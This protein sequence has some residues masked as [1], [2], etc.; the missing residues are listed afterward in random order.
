MKFFIKKRA[1]FLFLTLFVTISSFA[2]VTYSGGG[3]GT[4]SNPY[5]LLTLNDWNKFADSVTNGNSYAGKYLKLGADIANVTNMVGTYSSGT[6]A[7]YDPFKGN[8]D[9]DWHKITVSLNNNVNNSPVEFAAPFAIV[10]G[11]T[12]SNLIVDG[13]ITN[14]DSKNAAGIVSCVENKSD[15][16]TYIKNCISS[17][18]ITSDSEIAAP[19]HG[20][21]V[22]WLYQGEL[23]FE[24]CIFEGSIYG[25]TN[26]CAGFLGLV[27]RSAYNTTQVTYTNCAQVHTEI[28]HRPNTVFGTFHLPANIDP[29]GNW[30]TAYFT[31]RINDRDNQGTHAYCD[32]D[33]N[34]LPSDYN[35]ILKKYQREHAGDE[36]TFYIPE[37]VTDI[38][39]TNI[40]TWPLNPTVKF[41][42]RTLVKDVDYTIDGKDNGDGTYKIWIYAASNAYYGTLT[43]DNVHVNDVSSW[44]GLNSL[45]S[46]TGTQTKYITLDKDYEAGSGDAAFT[47]KGSVVLD[48]N[49]HKINRKLYYKV[50]STIYDTPQNNGYVLYV[51]KGAD[52]TIKDT[53]P[54]HSGVITGGNNIGSGGGIKSVGNLTL[55]NIKVDFNK[56][57]QKDNDWGYG[58]GVY[59]NSELR[60]IGGSVTNNVAQGGGGGIYTEGTLVSIVDATIRGNKAQSKGGGIRIKTQGGTMNNCRVL[61]NTL[62]GI[63]AQDG[64]GIYNDGQGGVVIT[65]CTISGNNAQH[66]GGGFYQLKTASTVMRNCT[67]TNNTALDAGGGGIYL[68]AGSIRLEDCTI[69][70]NV[71]NVVGG[72]CVTKNTSKANG[73]L[74]IKGNV[75][76]YDNIGDATKP[77]V[78]LEGNDYV[79]HVVGD[80][81]E[82][83]L[84]GISRNKEGEV[85]DGLKTY[86][87]TKSNFRSDNYKL[88]WLMKGEDPKTEVSLNSTLRWSKPKAWQGMIEYTP[89]GQC[90]IQAPVIIDKV[91]DIPNPSNITLTG[92]GAIFIEE[93]GQL[94]YAGTPVPMSVIKTINPPATTTGEVYGWYT[95]SSPI[96]EPKLRG[97]NADVNL[98][99]SY[100]EPFNFDL[101][102]YNES[103]EMWET[104]VAHMNDHTFDILE[105]GRGYLYRNALKI[106][107]DYRGYN[108][109][110]NVKVTLTTNGSTL[111]G[112]N[113][114]G[115]PYT[116]DIYKG[117]SGC[118]IT[119]S[120]TSGYTLAEGYYKLTNAGAW[121][122]K[123][124]D[125]NAIKLGESILVKAITAGDMIITNTMHKH[126]KRS[127]NEY[128]AFTVSNDNYEDVTYAMFDEGI[129]LDKINHRNDEVQMVYIKQNDE[130]YAIAMMS[131]DTKTFDLNFRAM[132]MGRYTLS[133]N[134]K[135]EFSY[136]HVYDK[137][138]GK[139]IDMIAEK[140]YSFVGS[141]NDTDSR[142]IV[143][144][145]YNPNI[146]NSCF[147]YQNGNDIIVNGNGELQVFDVL[148]RLVTTQHINGVETYGR[149]SLST[150]VYIF[151]LNDKVQKIVVR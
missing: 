102:R 65:N 10:D 62:T 19:Y 132:T 29:Q 20:G 148:G 1:L 53:S 16:P 38:N 71:S 72:V 52:L 140:E 103:T 104:F 114:I 13:V 70:G 74:E 122:P 139:D 56:C 99:T 112:W 131:D 4:E 89:G 63:D 3:T 7:S 82:N 118:A 107:I 68:F 129:S 58:G 26:N 14:R 31:H 96:N 81:D 79:I 115:N 17:V 34:P 67:I 48:L 136:L 30:N 90:T 32:G 18:T 108:I 93:G 69:S 49:G 101:L 111:K 124:D 143:S 86:R 113:L 133:Y 94:N 98:V 44:S 120:G 64:A 119:N 35:G 59:C 66:R 25:N 110:E 100:S 11:A 106:S 43:V 145:Q 105:K 61:N 24:N 146:G 51:A 147:A 60:I 5:V 141:P 75:Y 109:S 42:G 116:H 45:L 54:S 55:E 85:T 39:T 2:Q 123:I 92:E 88:Y 127:N 130:N 33:D 134:T 97:V 84:I 80:L 125:G 87:G 8:F 128:I 57:K 83:A 151:K 126:T 23:F 150:G 50:G 27:D 137:L 6:F 138:A 91:N 46:S 121:E 142:F 37:V 76:I 73:V 15:K 135:G 28:E 21:L 41:F 47:V 9:G 77:N 12:I 149:T 22:G 78:F 95:I 40:Y 144:L 36:K 117:D